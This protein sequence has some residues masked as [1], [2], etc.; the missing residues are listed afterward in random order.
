L[1]LK[2][3]IL[4]TALFWLV[5]WFGIWKMICTAREGAP[6]TF[7]ITQNGEELRKM[8][9]SVR[10]QAGDQW[11]AGLPYCIETMILLYYQKSLTFEK[12]SNKARCTKTNF[13]PTGWEGNC[14]LHREFRASCGNLQFF[15]GFLLRHPSFAGF[16]YSSSISTLV[17]CFYAGSGFLLRTLWCTTQSGGHLENSLAKYGYIRDMKV[18]KKKS[19]II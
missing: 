19:G 15:I 5:P 8:Y 14:D 9:Q 16:F 1:Q 4:F 12:Y 7:L 11:W 3:R 10:S 17:M 13:P 2:K 6:I 18:G